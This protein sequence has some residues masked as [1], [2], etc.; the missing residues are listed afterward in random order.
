[1]M[2]MI[3][4]CSCIEGYLVEVNERLETNTSL[5]KTKV[6]VRIREL[7]FNLYVRGKEMPVVTP[8]VSIQQ[9]FKKRHFNDYSTPTKL[10]GLFFTVPGPWLLLVYY[11]KTRT[12]L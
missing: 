8:V 12:H 6:C 5:L 11:T 3:T 4:F 1:M 7:T 2:K 10:P 9:F